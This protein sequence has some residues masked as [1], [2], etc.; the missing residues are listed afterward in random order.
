MTDNRARAESTSLIRILSFSASFLE[1]II[2]NFVDGR[3]EDMAI[4]RH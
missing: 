3:L 2:S 4:K 1:F